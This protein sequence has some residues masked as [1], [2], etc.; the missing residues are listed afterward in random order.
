M[1]NI[2]KVGL[3]QLEFLSD[4]LRALCGLIDEELSSRCL[5]WR[6]SSF[7]SISSS[8]SCNI[9]GLALVFS[10]KMAYDSAGNL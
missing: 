9:K 1:A 7:E 3:A 4:S 5:R 6:T 10:R 2:P 8:C